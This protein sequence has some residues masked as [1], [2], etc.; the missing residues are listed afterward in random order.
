MECKLACYGSARGGAARSY[1]LE[2][3]MEETEGKKRE[4]KK[5]KGKKRERKGKGGEERKEKGRE[6]KE[7]LKLLYTA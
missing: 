4:R 7:D 5:R 6:E 1:I 3:R 2:F